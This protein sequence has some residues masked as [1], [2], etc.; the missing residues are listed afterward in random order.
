MFECFKKKPVKK[1][2]SRQVQHEP[3]KLKRGYPASWL[4]S[5]LMITGKYEGSGFGQVTGNFDGQ[6]ISAGILQWNY[7]QGSLQSKILLPLVN[8]MGAEWVDNFFPVSVSITATMS[9]RKAKAY[10]K[11]HMLTGSIFN[12]KYV[13]SNW[14]RQWQLFLTQDEVIEVQREACASVASKAFKYCEDHGMMSA[15]S[16]CWFF[17]IVTQN[18]SLKGVRKP[19]NLSQYSEYLVDDGGKNFNIWKQHNPS[20]ETKILFI[21]TCKRVVRNQWASDVIARKG[22]IAHGTGV[23]HGQIHDFRGLIG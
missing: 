22:T 13:D 2:V 21:W 9:P 17:D 6:G 12:K 7:G 5:A 19:I 11:K 8:K 4:D 16:F 20:D 23:V 10:A 15:K 14:A 1:P 18:G 3:T